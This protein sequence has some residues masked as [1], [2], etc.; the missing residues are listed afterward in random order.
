[1]LVLAWGTDESQSAG[2]TKVGTVDPGG[3][4]IE[5]VEYGVAV[6]EDEVADEHVVGRTHDRTEALETMSQMPQARR[7]LVRR[8][9]AGWVEAE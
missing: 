4:V 1:M 2:P 5:T 6:Q 3:K 8:T 7:Y 9:A